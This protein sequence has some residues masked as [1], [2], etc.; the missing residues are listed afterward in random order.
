MT[1]KPRPDLGSQHGPTQECT[2]VTSC[3]GSRYTLDSSGAGSGNNGGFN[4]SRKHVAHHA[5]NS[6]KGMGC[7]GSCTGCSPKKSRAA[8]LSAA[9]REPGSGPVSSEQGQHP[10]I[11]LA[12]RQAQDLAV[13]LVAPELTAERYTVRLGGSEGTPLGTIGECRGQAGCRHPSFPFNLTPVHQV[14]NTLAHYVTQREVCA[15]AARLS[16][17]SDAS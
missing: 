9:G 3:S 17:I 16:A 14:K 1:P 7:I 11:H 15:L 4:G 13:D 10:S 6:G 2:M 8:D 5:H 12:A